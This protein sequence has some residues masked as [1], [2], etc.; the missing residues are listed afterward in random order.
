[1]PSAFHRHRSNDRTKIRDIAFRR[2][3]FS[4][5]TLPVT[6]SVLA[7]LT[8]CGHDTSPAVAGERA[9]H[10]IDWGVFL[11]DDGA[12]SSNLWTVREM[13]GSQPR[14]VMRFAALDDRTPIPE[15]NVIASSGAQPIITLEPWQP[16][17]GVDQP[18][19]ALSHI[20]SGDF[21]TQ[22]DT[23]AHNLAEW[24]QPV[25][26]RFAH[27]MNSDH[28]PW[29]VGVNGNS[30]E[31]YRAA[32]AHVR[33]RFSR[34]RAGNVSFMWCPDAPG[35]GSNDLAST[36][37]GAESV[38]LL[39]LDGY[40]WGDGSG[41]TWRNPEQIFTDGLNQLRA[42]EG[43]RPIVIAETASVEGPQS[44][45]DKAAWINK[46]FEF[47]SREDRVA[48]VVWFQMDKERDWRLNSSG[49]SQQ[50]FK[51]ALADR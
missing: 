34:A 44:G 50:A 35:E 32:W 45:T 22:I 15:L 26:L 25:V 29:S 13:T 4:Q 10:W 6:V 37:P 9:S 41:H 8:G 42:L 17:A 51:R 49:Q 2:P 5:L 21:D 40:N 23:W 47:L 14:Y 46:L 27:E 33:E 16:G 28:Y 20:A 43:N 48:A 7:V 30:A 12:P 24:G 19:Y 36:Y 1:M 18:E 3:R 11:P 31:D 38:D 39:C